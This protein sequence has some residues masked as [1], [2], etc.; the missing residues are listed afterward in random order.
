MGAG[1]AV[2]E[3][4]VALEAL[5]DR[6]GSIELVGEPEPARGRL[7]GTFDPLHLHVT[8]LSGATDV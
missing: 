8:R 2:L 3:L 4:Q 7:F 1:L 6:L 5:L